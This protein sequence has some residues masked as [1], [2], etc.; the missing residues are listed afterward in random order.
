MEN[1]NFIDN[2]D[3]IMTFAFTVNL[4]KMTYMCML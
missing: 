1:I 3:G 4:I 2:K